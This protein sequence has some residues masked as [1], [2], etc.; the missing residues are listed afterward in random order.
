MKNGIYKFYHYTHFDLLKSKIDNFIFFPHTMKSMVAVTNL[1]YKHLI[2][3][4][5]EE[6]HTGL[7]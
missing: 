2:L 4:S 5:A 3:C 7:E 6:N 1:F